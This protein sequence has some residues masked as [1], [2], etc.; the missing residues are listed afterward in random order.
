MGKR[1][2][3]A[4]LVAGTAGVLLLASSAGAFGQGQ[5][6]F[7]VS[8]NGTHYFSKAVVH[9][10]EPTAE[11]KIQRSSDTIELTGDLKGQVL[12]HVTSRFDYARGRLVNTG[13]QVFSGTVAGSEPVLL[14]DD[15]FR[16]EVDLNTGATTGEVHFRRSKDVG[17][18]EWYECDL[19]IVGTGMTE[20]GD[21]TVAYTGTC[22]RRGA[23]KP[24]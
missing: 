8:G 23:T 17:A 15:E 3:T 7:A 16:F 21:A 14:F 12:Y 1:G 11:G 2:S 5:D 20:S 4:A 24:S 18:V 22:V 13:S 6:P 9:S 10:E 19:Q